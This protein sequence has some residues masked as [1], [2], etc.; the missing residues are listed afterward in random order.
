[1]KAAW[2]DIDAIRGGTQAMRDAGELD[3]ASGAGRVPRCLQPLDGSTGP[4]LAPPYTWLMRVF[5]AM[6]LR[7]PIKVLNTGNLPEADFRA[8][9]GYH[10]GDDDEGEPVTGHLED[11]NREGA[12]LQ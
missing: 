12:S 7:K 10:P 2:A 11:V 4:P 1:M 3:P 8:I 9:A 5:V 6:I